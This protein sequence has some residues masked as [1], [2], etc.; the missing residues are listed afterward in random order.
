MVN[1]CHTH[2][3]AHSVQLTVMYRSLTSISC[4]VC[5]SV[6]NSSSLNDDVPAFARS[7]PS[8]PPRAAAAAVL[9]SRAPL[10]DDNALFLGL[11]YVF[12]ML[13]NGFLR[14]PPPLARLGASSSG[15][16]ENGRTPSCSGACARALPSHPQNIGRFFKAGRVA[17]QL[18][19]CERF[20]RLLRKAGTVVVSWLVLFGTQPSKFRAKRNY[21]SA[22]RDD[23]NKRVDFV[24]K[25]PTNV[26]SLRKI[27]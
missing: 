1:K 21:V 4:C 9:P 16:G 3:R 23:V 20:R 10:C 26:K 11:L 12:S 25:H 24:V 27:K 19:H 17:A 18:R 7:S 2:T 14:F 8:F 15:P 6:L 5:R 22:L 13:T